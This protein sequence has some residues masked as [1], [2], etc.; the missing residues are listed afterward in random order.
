MSVF[1]L[2]LG[3][4]LTSCG[5]SRSQ[6]FPSQDTSTPDLTLLSADIF[7][8][9]SPLYVGSPLPSKVWPI[10]YSNG[11]STCTTTNKTVA[12]ITCG[13]LTGRAD[14]HF[15]SLR[16]GNIILRAHGT[17]TIHLRTPITS[18]AWQKAPVLR[19][20]FNVLDPQSYGSS[21]EDVDTDDGAFQLFLVFGNSETKQGFM[22]RSPV[23]RLMITHVMAFNYMPVSDKS[24]HGSVSS[25]RQ[26]GQLPGDISDQIEKYSA[27]NMYGEAF[28]AQVV[29][30]QLENS[31]L[32]K[33]LYALRPENAK[34]YDI[35]GLPN[36]PIDV[37]LDLL[38][39]AKQAFGEGILSKI[40]RLVAVLIE[41]TAVPW[42]GSTD[43]MAEVAIRNIQLKPP[44]ESSLAVP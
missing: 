33:P 29:K 40:P 8:S 34:F 16:D 13:G 17:D 36:T 23:R 27:P 24:K 7:D 25:A 12:F 5:T 4:C 2:V 32:S 6:R 31:D 41:S 21:L 9:R 38:Q 30:S 1:L 10:I 42:N 43:I 15:L 14:K 22:R 39:L 28:N 26:I 3:F 20:Q 11:T 19:L 35:F 44:R 18:I 37:E